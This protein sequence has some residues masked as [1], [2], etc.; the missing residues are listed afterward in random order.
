MV[1]FAMTFLVGSDVYSLAAD[2][3]PL[4]PEQRQALEILSR[5]C[6]EQSIKLNLIA[7]DILFVNNLSILHARDAYQDRPDLGKSR[8]LFSMMLRDNHLALQKPACFREAGDNVFGRS[9][10]KQI[11][12]TVDEWESFAAGPGRPKPEP[13]LR[14]D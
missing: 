6:R 4:I 7:G 10:E 12:L 14:N 9:P 3:P 11:L 1:N 5:I 2:A 8:L 13:N